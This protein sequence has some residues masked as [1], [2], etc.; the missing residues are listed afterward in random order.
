M[1]KRIPLLLALALAPVS[2]PAAFAQDAVDGDREGEKEKGPE[3]MPVYGQTV[4]VTATRTEST[5]VDSPVSITVVGPETIEN[6]TS[7]SALKPPIAVMMPTTVPNRPTNGDVAP[8]VPSIQR[9]E[10]RS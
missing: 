4:V 10:R 7:S 9:R 5:V 6:L 3:E 2:G 1:T 8:I